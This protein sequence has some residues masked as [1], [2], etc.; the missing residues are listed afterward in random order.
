MGLG[1]L[2]SQIAIT[3]ALSA[4]IAG[5]GCLIAAAIGLGGPASPVVAPARRLARH[6]AWLAAASALTAAAC[7]AAVRV[8]SDRPPA[9]GFASVELGLAVF[10]AICLVLPA[11]L[12]RAPHS[13]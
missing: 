3:A 8:A 1:L 13:G 9:A 5:E 4:A 10:A 12:L 2:F 11:T 6:M 7:A